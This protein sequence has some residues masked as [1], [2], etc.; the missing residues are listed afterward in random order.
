MGL[1]I[2]GFIIFLFF[3]ALFGGDASGVASVIALIIVFGPGIYF[4]WFK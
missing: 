2:A 4:K 1:L 3:L